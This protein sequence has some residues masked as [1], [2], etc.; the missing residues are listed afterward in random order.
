M[1][2]IWIK[3]VLQYIFRLKIHTLTAMYCNIPI[4]IYRDIV[5]PP[6][7]T[8]LDLKSNHTHYKK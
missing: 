4:Y 2:D 5:P 7:D 3:Y 1:Y 6:Q 8:T